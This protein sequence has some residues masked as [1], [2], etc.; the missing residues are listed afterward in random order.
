MVRY[1]V[2]WKVP[3]C[4]MHTG[5]AIAGLKGER[6]CAYSISVQ[7]KSCFALSSAKWM[8]N[9]SQFEL[10]EWHD[11][12]IFFPWLT[13]LLFPPWWH[14]VAYC[15]ERIPPFTAVCLLVVKKKK[16]GCLQAGV[17]LLSVLI[18]FICWTSDDI[19]L[20]GQEKT[21]E[22]KKGGGQLIATRFSEPWG[23]WGNADVSELT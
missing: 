23:V 12:F 3:S 17:Y 16:N 21:R 9:I 18:H 2:I 7:K 11:L 1:D 4:A 20:K 6:S 19:C 14:K 8:M 13:S 5:V 22:I 15:W 10:F